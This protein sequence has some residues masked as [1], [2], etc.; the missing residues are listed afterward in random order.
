MCQRF[1]SLILFSLLACTSYSQTIPDSPNTDLRRFFTQ[2]GATYL[3]KHPHQTGTT[4][5]LPPN[6]T[7]QFQGGSI[8]GKLV[9]NNTQL[10]GNVKL[11]GSSISGTLKNKKLNAK[12]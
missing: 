10:N 9:F 3:I 12:W 6:V 8:A 2:A 5:T 11:H 7:L 4:I 1:L